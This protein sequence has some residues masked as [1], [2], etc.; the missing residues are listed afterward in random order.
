M[1]IYVHRDIWFINIHIESYEYLSILTQVTMLNKLRYIYEFNLKQ[2][3]RW[4]KWNKKIRN[5]LV[6]LVLV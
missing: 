5:H 3:K 2:L 6:R 1:L 4:I